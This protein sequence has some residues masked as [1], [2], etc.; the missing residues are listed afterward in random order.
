MTM[1]SIK[2]LAASLPLLVSGV[3]LVNQDVSDCGSGDSLT[4][5]NI[6]AARC[7]DS[8][9]ML[10]IKSVAYSG[11]SGELHGVLDYNED[12]GYQCGAEQYAKLGNALADCLDNKGYTVY[13]GSAWLDCQAAI[14]CYTSDV[15]SKRSKR[16]MDRP[17]N[18]TG[19]SRVKITESVKPDIF[20]TAGKHY[21]INGVMRV[22][23][24]EV[25]VHGRH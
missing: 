4:C 5:R 21:F 25:A 16:T 9:P 14:D 2:V 8:V 1:A 13:G 3:N 6:A 22:R 19:L 20:T 10:G 12:A 17:T 15:P 11:F 23:G 18:A 7:C 24:A